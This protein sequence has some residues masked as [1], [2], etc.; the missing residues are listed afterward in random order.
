MLKL[1][2]SQVVELL[3]SKQV[4]PLQLIDEVAAQLEALDSQVNAV[5]I[6]CLDRARQKAASLAVPECPGGL[7]VSC[8][9]LQMKT[10]S[11]ASLSL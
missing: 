8:V 5:P 10:F 7:L 1:T 6:R 4:T 3:K 11:M 2:A 9:N